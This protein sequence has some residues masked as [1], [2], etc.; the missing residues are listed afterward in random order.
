LDVIFRRLLT[1]RTFSGV[2][3]IPVRYLREEIQDRNLA[4]IEIGAREYRVT[5]D[6]ARTYLQAHATAA[7]LEALDRASPILFATHISDAFIAWSERRF[8]EY[9]QNWSPFLK[10]LLVADIL[11]V[12]AQHLRNLVRGGHL[13]VWYFPMRSY[14]VRLFQLTEFLAAHRT[15]DRHPQPSK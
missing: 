11:N 14:R 6:H 8:P 1:L 4:A 10:P 15:P 5:Y 9:P 2:S 7:S 12:S 3:G 13:D